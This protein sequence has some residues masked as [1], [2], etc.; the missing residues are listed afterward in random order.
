M[1]V[2]YRAA[3]GI[4]ALLVSSVCSVSAEDFTLRLQARCGRQQQTATGA[5]PRPLLA[6]KAGLPIRVQWFAQNGDKP[7]VIHDV[8]LHCF[9][10]REQAAGQAEA[11]KP[12]P[13]AVYESALTMDF[14]PKAHSSA[15]FVVQSP[16]P[17]IYVL[18]IETLGAAKEHGHE[19]SAAMDVKIE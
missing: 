4:A 8:T 5:T 3:G 18:R 11:P 2:F 12:G 1:H 6:A 15:D 14:K 19:H 10:T 9:M 16:G 7:G 13:D 17:G